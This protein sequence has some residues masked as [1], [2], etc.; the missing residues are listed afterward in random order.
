MNRIARRPTEVDRWDRRQG[1][2]R[3]I[4]GRPSLA[5]VIWGRCAIPRQA[6]NPPHRRSDIVLSLSSM[7]PPIRLSEM[8]WLLGLFGEQKKKNIRHRR[9]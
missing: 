2:T 5:F 7:G 9:R 3:T 8:P 4:R 6:E 1:T